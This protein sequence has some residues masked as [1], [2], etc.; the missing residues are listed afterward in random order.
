MSSWSSTRRHFTDKFKLNQ[1]PYNS[2]SVSLE[3]ILRGSSNNT[4]F[5]DLAIT[6]FTLLKCIN[7][8]FINTNNIL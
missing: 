8:G 2:P 3:Y 6:M 5:T 7:T 4:S 1:T